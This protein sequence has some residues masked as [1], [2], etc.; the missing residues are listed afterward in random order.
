MARETPN[1]ER[2]RRVV[3]HQGVSSR[4]GCQAS[5]VA[6]GAVV[7]A[8]FTGALA[9]G[10]LGA[11]AACAGAPA[12]S[13]GPEPSV[14]VPPPSAEPTPS[15]AP[16]EAASAA[17]GDGPAAVVLPRIG[18]SIRP[19]GAGK[20]ED[21]DKEAAIRG[22]G[23]VF[24]LHRQKELEK[25]VAVADARRQIALRDAAEFGLRGLVKTADPPDDEPHTSVEE[26]EIGPREFLM[27]DRASGH[28]HVHVW[29]RSAEGGWVWADCR[30]DSLADLPRLRRACLS[31]ATT[32]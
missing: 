5:A 1:P 27:A 9:L 2:S 18:A 14:T 28:A 8:T 16:T 4:A 3:S 11:L 6:S 12:P 17:P 23:F 26:V 30:A 13:A 7:H 10:L 22:D 15:V 25:V 21:A 29:R 20:I 31:L 19:L 24:R 32:R